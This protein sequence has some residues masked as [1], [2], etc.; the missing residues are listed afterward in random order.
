MR[1]GSRLG[2]GRGSLVDRATQRWVRLTGRAVDLSHA[3]WLAGPVGGTRAIGPGFFH[4]LA[5]ERGCV[6]REAPTARGL[7][8]R[9]EDLAG[10]GFDPASIHP[11][12]RAFY[13]ET[14]AYALDVWAA[15]SPAFRPFGALVAALFSRRLEQ[16]NVPLDS[17]ATR[18]GMESAILELVDPAGEPLLTGWVRRNPATGETVYVGSYA[19]V[20][21]PGWPSPC[22]KV[23]FPL[24]NGSATVLLRPAAGAGGALVLESSG[25][26]FGDPG[27]YFVVRGAGERAW[28]RY[29]RGFRERIEVYAADDGALR[30]DHAFSLWG[31]TVLRLHYRMA[32]T[33]HR[34]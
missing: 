1:A 14:A 9:F 30:T 18:L 15:W 6:L 17:F 16:L 3:A 2:G 11:A 26:R 21:A 29:L 7:M 13:E 20:R 28:V 33:R 23:V 34:A 32:A 27:F 5:A 31:H 25:A 19:V 4:A 12:V 22:V 24:P 10:P 8:R